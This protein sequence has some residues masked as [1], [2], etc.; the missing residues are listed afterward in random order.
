MVAL[1]RVPFILKPRVSGLRVAFGW[2]LIENRIRYCPVSATV[3][4]LLAKEKSSTEDW[5]R[6]RTFCVPAVML[7]VEVPL[8]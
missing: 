6:G 5:V 3:M 8:L 1:S 4:V 7:T 2:I